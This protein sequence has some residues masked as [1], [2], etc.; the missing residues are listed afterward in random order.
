MKQKINDLQKERDMLL[1]FN[2]QITGTAMT[3]AGLEQQAQGETVKLELAHLFL[4]FNTLN[5]VDFFN[6]IYFKEFK[7]SGTPPIELIDEWKKHLD[8]KLKPV[9]KE[10]SDEIKNEKSKNSYFQ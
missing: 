8:D 6:K 7:Y 3:F 9:Y 4:K 10:L 1:F 2:S 5:F